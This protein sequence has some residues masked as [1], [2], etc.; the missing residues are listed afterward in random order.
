MNSLDW[1]DAGLAVRAWLLLL[2]FTAGVLLVLALR[3]PARRIFGAECAFLLWLLPLVAMLASQWPHAASRSG[4][5]TLV[6][7]ITTAGGALASRHDST[8][9][10]VQG[11][12]W[13]GIWLA[14]AALVAALMVSAQWRYR[15]RL[16]DAEC[17]TDTGLRWPVWRATHDDLGPALIGAWRACIVLPADFET[18]YDPVEQTLILAHETAHARRGDGW[19]ALFAQ[20]VTATF[21]FHPLAW[22]A[23]ATLRRD[24]ELACDAHVLRTHGSQRRRYANAMLKTQAVAPVLPVGCTWSPRHPLSERIAMLKQASVS[25]S[26]RRVGIGIGS[27]LAVALACSIHATSAPLRTP[28]S[29]AAMAQEYQLDLRIELT[30]SQDHRQHVD[31]STLALCTRAGQP[32]SVR[33]SA[34]GGRITVT[35]YPVGATRIDLML[36]MT[37]KASGASTTRTLQASLGKTLH[38]AGKSSDGQYAYQLA[39]TPLAGCPARAQ[40]GVRRVDLRLKNVPAR[41]AAEELARKA[42]LVLVNPGALTTAPVSFNFADMP[43]DRAMHLIARVA[44]MKA[45]IDGRQV[46]FVQP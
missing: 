25:R 6:Y 3:R 20:V 46:R 12:G 41:T 18:R 39:M 8:D 36:V 34:Y 42:D 44:G 7:A 45:V 27:M 22:L 5:P 21:W 23:L 17:L 9:A 32:A 29:G 38:V 16:A 33:E 11:I 43:G 15:R 26:R 19:W 10:L 1:S 40:A 28:A 4:L 31:R 13:L 35:P 2:A 37:G 14:G 30:N 24:Q